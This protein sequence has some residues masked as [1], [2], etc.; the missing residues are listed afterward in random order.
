MND[1]FVKEGD[2]V[3]EFE[4]VAEVQSDKATVEITSR[5]CHVMFTVD[6]KAL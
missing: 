1:R 2:R 3:R 6:M 4:K 5:Y